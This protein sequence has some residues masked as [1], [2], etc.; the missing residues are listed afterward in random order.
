MKRPTATFLD[1]EVDILTFMVRNLQVAMVSVMLGL[2]VYSPASGADAVSA[3]LSFVGVS[4]TMSTWTLFALLG[5]S[6]AI[7]GL[8]MP[9]IA[10]G[11]VQA[12]VRAHRSRKLAPVD[13]EVSMI[14]TMKALK[15]TLLGSPLIAAAYLVSAVTAVF[16]DGFLPGTLLL[17]ASAC[18]VMTYWQVKSTVFSGYSYIWLLGMQAGADGYNPFKARTAREVFESGRVCGEY[19]PDQMQHDLMAIVPMAMARLK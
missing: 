4:S 11:K 14:R 13:F 12:M 16:L 9:W 5:L 19:N 18:S 15:W 1:H 7:T 3:I 8:M 6:A 2:L 10:R 17:G